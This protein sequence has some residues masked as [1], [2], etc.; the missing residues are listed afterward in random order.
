MATVAAVRGLSDIDGGP[1]VS[2]CDSGHS[3][4]AK[5]DVVESSVIPAAPE[6]QAIRCSSVY[7]DEFWTW[8]IPV[9]AWRISVSH[10][11]CEHAREWRSYVRSFPVVANGLSLEELAVVSPDGRVFD[12]DGPDYATVA[13]WEEC[14]RGEWERAR[15]KANGGVDEES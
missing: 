11:Y 1:I 7:D 12:V 8:I 3:V 5:C 9:I 13:E 15:S 10:N 4:I 6:W 2:W 14:V